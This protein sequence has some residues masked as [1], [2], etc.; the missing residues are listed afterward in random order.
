MKELLIQEECQEQSK[1]GTAVLVYE[2]AIRP[3]Q[4]TEPSAVS[5]S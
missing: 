1:L 5:S 4:I 3:S 2:V